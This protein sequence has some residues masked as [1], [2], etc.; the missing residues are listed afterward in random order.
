VSDEFLN[1]GII[2]GFSGDD[3]L[4]LLEKLTWQQCKSGVDA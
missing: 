4:S 3:F 2:L 1:G